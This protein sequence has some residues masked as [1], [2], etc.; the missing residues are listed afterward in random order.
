MK[1]IVIAVRV[2][3]ITGSLFLYCGCSTYRISQSPDTPVFHLEPG[4][5]CKMAAYMAGMY[6]PRLGIGINSGRRLSARE[7]FGMIP[8]LGWLVVPWDAWDGASGQTQSQYVFEHNLEPIASDNNLSSV[9]HL[10]KIGLL[11]AE[12]VDCYIQ[13]A[14]SEP[15]LNVRLLREVRKR[16]LPVTV[17]VSGRMPLW[18]GDTEPA[19]DDYLY[20]IDA[21]IFAQ[22]NL[23]EHLC[24][25]LD[26]TP[27]PQIKPELAETA[28]ELNLIDQSWTQEL[29]YMNFWT[30]Y[31]WALRDRAFAN[32]L[33]SN[34]A[35]MERYLVNHHLNAV[36]T[37]HD[38]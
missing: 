3:V 29:L 21:G 35:S 2:I 8:V 37:E 24:R 7:R 6:D 9:L 25:I 14:M 4:D 19:L 10:E 13:D 15:Y 23:L 33:P 32:Q 30:Y 20:L 22:S 36:E 38:D 16:N 5:N 1:V 26:Q 31:D 28:H 34:R 27:M 11:N 12:Q 17:A 18:I